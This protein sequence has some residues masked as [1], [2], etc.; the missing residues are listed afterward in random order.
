MDN[1][2]Q[3]QA[4]QGILLVLLCAACLGILSGSASRRTFQ[5]SLVFSSLLGVACTSFSPGSW[6][7]YLV[8]FTA[9][10]CGA[11]LLGNGLPVLIVVTAL[12]SAITYFQA[13][14]GGLPFFVSWGSVLGTLVGTVI[15]RG[16]LTE[17]LFSLG[18][19]FCLSGLVL[20]WCPGY[21]ALTIGLYLAGF[22]ALGYQ[23]TASRR[24]AGSPVLED[25]EHER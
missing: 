2:F 24:R 7:P 12:F 8:G 21:T 23:A 25:S 22:L 10:G 17:K 15:L 13:A 1:P 6:A 3:H 9:L 5:R 16:L 19:L 11:G 14:F 20:S 18:T 4:F